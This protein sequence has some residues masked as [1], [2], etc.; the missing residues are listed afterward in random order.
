MESYRDWIVGKA[1]P[2]WSTAGFDDAA[3]RFHERLDATGAPRAVPYRAMVQARQIYVFA[4]AALLGW[5]DTGG[6]LAER[7]MA[8]LRRDFLDDAGDRA[9]VAF[10]IDRDGRVVSAVRDAY[11]H[12]F[13]LF[14]LAW[15]HRLNGDPELLALADRVTRFLE[16]EMV[17]PEHGG[18]F[19]ALPLGDATKRQ[20]PLM[21]LLEAYLALERAAPG[22]G[23]AERARGVVAL[24]R[25]RLFEP[26]RG[27]I[28]E[29]FA[30][31]WSA[32]AD[33]VRTRLFEPGHHFEWVWLLDEYAAVVGDDVGDLPERLYEVAAGHGISAD[34]LIYDE[35]GD[36]LR[37]LKRSHRLWPHTEAIKAAAARGAID[38]DAPAFAGRMA[39]TLLEEFLDR[40]FV[41]GWTDQ[42]GADRRPLIDYVPASSLYHLFFAAAEADRAFPAGHS[43]AKREARRRVGATP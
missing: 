16:T 35:V 23:Y 12:A 13:V 32:H 18:L 2:F 43:G 24:F 29:Y 9:S 39:R 33:P 31:D 3:G 21:H 40:P 1:L 8:G 25:E 11:A 41:G 36:D 7:A 19:D 14:A 42:I 20:N 6:T 15:L 22:R 5:S 37:V 27:V 26:R 28:L 17:D 38:P 30:A 4:H 10:S 34:G